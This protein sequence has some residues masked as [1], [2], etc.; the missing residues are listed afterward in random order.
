LLTIS[1][2]FSLKT[3]LIMKNTFKVIFTLLSYM[4]SS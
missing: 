4:K 2:H 1:K 3:I